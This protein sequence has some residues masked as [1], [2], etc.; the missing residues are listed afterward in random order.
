MVSVGMFNSPML[1]LFLFDP[2]EQSRRCLLKILYFFPHPII[3]SRVLRRGSFLRMLKTAVTVDDYV[4]V[5]VDIDSLGTLEG[6]ELAI[7]ESIAHL[8]EL[9]ELVDEL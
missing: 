9:S 5:K 1:G 7:V 3:L 8:P 4:V 6:I 2:M